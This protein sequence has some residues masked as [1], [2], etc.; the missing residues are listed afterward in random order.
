LPKAAVGTN[1]KN[2]HIS[3]RIVVDLRANVTIRPTLQPFCV[4]TQLLNSASPA[5]TSLL[6]SSL[7]LQLSAF[8]ISEDSP[9]LLNISTPQP[10]NF[11]FRFQLSAF[12]VSAFS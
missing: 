3:A 7:Y 4:S 1:D 9:F 10:L 5:R 11:F 8:S 2:H 6:T 12:S